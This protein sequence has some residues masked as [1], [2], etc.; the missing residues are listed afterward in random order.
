MT[1]SILPRDEFTLDLLA[2]VLARMF[3]YD[4]RRQ[5]AADR[6][7]FGDQARPAADDAPTLEADTHGEDTRL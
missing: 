2:V 1:T 4:R 5:V 3:E 7:E 6:D